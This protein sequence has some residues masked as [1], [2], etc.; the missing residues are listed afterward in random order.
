MAEDLVA[1]A[2]AAK[3]DERLSDGALYGKLADEI[4][5]LRRLLKS[6]RAAMSHSNEWGGVTDWK[7]MIA[8]IDRALEQHTRGNEDA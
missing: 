2:R 7:Y 6:C 8:D 4:E 3:A 5:R 1:M